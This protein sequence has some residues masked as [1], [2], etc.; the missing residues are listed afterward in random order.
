MVQVYARERT[1]VRSRAY[2]TKISLKHNR[3]HTF[4]ILLYAFRYTTQPAIFLI[5][6]FKNYHSSARKRIPTFSVLFICYT[7]LYWPPCVS[8]FELFFPKNSDINRS[9]LKRNAKKLCRLVQN[10]Y[11][12]RP[13]IICG[14]KNAAKLLVKKGLPLAG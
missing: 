2:N 11:F 3:L 14:V 4:E 7:T 5:I 10:A 12:C 1:I 6:Y 9:V 8:Y 13:I